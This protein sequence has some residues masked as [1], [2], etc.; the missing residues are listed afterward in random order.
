MMTLESDCVGCSPDLPCLGCSC[1]YFGR[2]PHFHCDVCG[3]D[4]NFQLDDK[5][6][7]SDCLSQKL[8]EEFDELSI[9][10]QAELLDHEINYW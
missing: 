6:Y 3:S 5:D 4:A 2:S 1:K 9:V 7:C 10:E 8:R